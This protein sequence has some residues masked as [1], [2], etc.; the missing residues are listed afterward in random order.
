MLQKPEPKAAPCYNMKSMEVLPLTL[1]QRETDPS[2]ACAV[3]FVLNRHDVEE[4]AKGSN[5]DS[6]SN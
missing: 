5:D 3:C 2:S 4:A 6:K 1:F